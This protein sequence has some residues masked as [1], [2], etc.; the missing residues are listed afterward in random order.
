MMK[1]LYFC[2]SV[3]ALSFGNAALAKDLPSQELSWSGLYG[4]V[5]AGGS[6]SNLTVLDGPGNVNCWWCVN[7][8]GHKADQMFVGGQI[9]Y[10][11]QIDQLVLGIEGELSNK[12]V[13]GKAFDPTHTGPSGRVDGGFY[14][15]ITGRLGYSLGP[16]LI[17]GKA[18][19]GA[20]DAHMSWA[21]P[22]YSSTASGHKTL[23]GAVFGGGIEYALSPA[24]SLKAEYMNLDLGGSKLLNVIGYPGGY[25]QRIKLDSID[26]F[27]VGVNFYFNA[28]K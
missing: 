9:G 7:N 12:M 10:N 25:Q 15:A 13:D 11:Y 1:I 19:W 8:Y 26:T 28:S 16:A 5:M 2:V 3:I 14:G 23:S 6:S 22:V 24:I 20:M 27:R 17:Y 18:G 21:D 4:G